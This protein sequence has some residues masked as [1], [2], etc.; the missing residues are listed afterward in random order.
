VPGETPSSLAIEV[1]ERLGRAVDRVRGSMAGAASR[2]DEGS[3]GVEGVCGRADSVVYE[4]EVVIIGQAAAMFEG[5]PTGAGVPGA[6][7]RRAAVRRLMTGPAIAAARSAYRDGNVLRRLAAYT[8]SVTG[9][10]VY[11]LALSWSATRMAGAS[12]AGLVVAASALPRAIFMLVGGVVADRFGPRRVAAVSDATRCV[13]ILV[14]AAVLTGYGC[15]YRS[16]VFRR[17]GCGV[18]TRRGRVSRPG[19]RHGNSSPGCRACGG[20]RFG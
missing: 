10:V 9:D 13:V 1:I 12:Q 16:L 2:P 5:G 7:H 8:A 4:P 20:C 15:W 6:R 3:G 11:F 18:H 17:G 19:L 14:S